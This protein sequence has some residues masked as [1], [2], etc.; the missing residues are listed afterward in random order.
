MSRYPSSGHAAEGRLVGSAQPCP[1]SSPVWML[2]QFG[3]FGKLKNS[4]RN[5]ARACRPAEVLEERDVPLLLAWVVDA[6]CGRVA[7]RAG[8]RIGERCGVEPE[9]AVA[10]G[11]RELL[12]RAGIH[13]AHQVHRLEEAAVADTRDVVAA[14]HRERRA[15][16]EERRARHLP[17]AEQVPHQRALVAQERQFVDVVDAHDMATVEVRRPPHVRCRHRYSR[18][19]SLVARVV[20]GLAKVYAKPT[21]RPFC[22]G[23]RR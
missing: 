18:A 5:C 8:R 1:C 9:V 15:G 13:I 12:V 17:A 6:G 10:D 16:A 21:F 4:A 7:E 3:W 23:D 19:R 14:Q 2:A 20:L 22:N 11:G